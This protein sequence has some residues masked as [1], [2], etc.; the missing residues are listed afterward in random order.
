[1]MKMRE[2]EKMARHTT[3][4]MHLD[5]RPYVR[6]HGFAFHF[7]RAYPVS[8][9]RAVQLSMRLVYCVVPRKRS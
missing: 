5:T 1:M 3:I 9:L 6:P 4:P 2:A 8:A 7:A